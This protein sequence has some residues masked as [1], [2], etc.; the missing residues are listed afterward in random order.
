MRYFLLRGPLRKGRP[1]TWT[2]DHHHV[3]QHVREVFGWT[4]YILGPLVDPALPHEVWM[5]SLLFC[6]PVITAFLC[7]SLFSTK[8]SS[9]S[10]LP[11][12]RP[13]AMAVWERGGLYTDN[14]AHIVQ[15]RWPCAFWCISSLIVLVD[16]L[17]TSGF[18]CHFLNHS[19][20]QHVNHQQLATPTCI[21]HVII[22]T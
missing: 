10:P 1:L 16:H 13:S 7:F 9:A 8:L 6:V 3:G 17:V 12:S 2:E 11:W 18:M 22:I 15:G 20:W 4:C 14:Y 19:N 21:H 5:A